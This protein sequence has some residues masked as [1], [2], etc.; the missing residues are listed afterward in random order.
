[1]EVLNNEK[2]DMV[3]LDLV[4]PGIDGFAFLNIVKSQSSTKYLP[5]IVLTARD[6]EEEIEEAKKLGAL[7]C[8]VKYKIKPAELVNIITTILS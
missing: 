4:M 1:M 7:D 3:I 6:S 5:V 2:V 8:L